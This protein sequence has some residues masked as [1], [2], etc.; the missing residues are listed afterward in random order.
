MKSSLLC[1]A[2]AA[3]L[4]FASTAPADDAA[5]LA[6]KW[7]FKKVNDEGQK[8][9][10]TVEIKPDGKFTFQIIGE[11]DQVA[12]VAQG[13]FK[14]DKLEPFKSVRFF[15]IKGGA[16]G[17]DLNDVD[18][19]FQS[20]YTLSEDTW[21]L[22]SNFD[23]DRQQKPA[24]DAYQRVKAPAAQTLVI[25]E[26]EMADVPQGATWFVCL[27]V[28]TPDGASHRY[29]VDGKEYD[30]KQVTIPVALELARVS[31]GQKCTF[32]LQLDDIDED[33]CGDEPDNHTTGEF[34]VNE[35][36]SQSYKPEDNWRYTI[37]WHLK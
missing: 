28:T 35:R 12:F 1:F 33:A 10:Q 22:A 34:S 5:A 2:F 25:D 13:D 21:T 3:S 15:R 31:A 32:K 37:R 6:G 7:S 11:D 17:S 24:L 26:I 18:D 4:L 16:P 30:K 23:K 14:L 9:T 36:G 29:H 20:V 19:E 8:Y 27:D